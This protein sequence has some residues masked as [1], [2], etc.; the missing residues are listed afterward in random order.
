MPDELIL[1]TLMLWEIVF[2][3]MLPREK[4]PYPAPYFASW[5]EKPLILLH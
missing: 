1:V 4:V 3:T 5:E 2:L